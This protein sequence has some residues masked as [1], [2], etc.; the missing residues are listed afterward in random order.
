MP[1]A[2]RYFLCV[3]A[4][5]AVGPHSLD[6]LREWVARSVISPDWQVCKEGGSDWINISAIPNFN[7]YPSKLRERIDRY[8]NTPPEVWWADKVTEKQ[9]KKLEYFDIPFSREGLTKGRASELIEAFIQIDPARE[10]QYQDRPAT[11]TQVRQLR[12]FGE[13]PEEL[14][15]SEAKEEI[16]ILQAEKEER[17]QEEAEVFD[18]LDLMVNHEDV[19][20]VCRYRALTKAQLKQLLA[21]L[22]QN[23]P[24]WQ[25]KSG[26]DLA[27]IVLKLFPDKAFKNRATRRGHR[28]HR[29]SSS[30]G[31]LILV[32]VILIAAFKSCNPH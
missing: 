11:P 26:Y 28:Q 12:A 16:E 23:T 14:T 4:G 29:K 17:Q 18:Y 32:C 15:Y 13:N 25:R 2:D 19:R 30:F 20:E 1:K 22:N 31:L 24:D 9:I 6:S 7:N 5:K 10:Q 27:P 21:Y 8:R 3:R